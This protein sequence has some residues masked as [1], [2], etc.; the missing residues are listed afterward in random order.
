M[1]IHP[2]DLTAS[3]PWAVIRALMGAQKTEQEKEEAALSFTL[4]KVGL[5]LSGGGFRASLFHIGVLARLAE[6][7]ILRHVEV[8]SCV[9]G[10]SILGAFYYLELR[11][12]LMEK[13]DGELGQQDYIDIV[14]RVQEKFLKGVQKN[15]RLRMLLEF[16]SNLRVFRGSSM[17][18]RL[19]V[20]YD[21]ELFDLVEDEF[22]PERRMFFW[23]RKRRSMSDILITPRGKAGE[24]FDP[25]YDNWTRKHKVPILI[26][27]ATTLNTCHN[28]QFTGNFMGEPPARSSENI[29]SNDRLRRLYY[30]EAPVR[31]RDQPLNGQPRSKV[32]LS[33]AVGASAAVPGLFDPL[34]LDGL[35]GTK[36]GDSQNLD[37]GLGLVDGGAWDNQ[38]AASLL[39]QNC[40][41]LLVSDASGQTGVALQPGSGRLEVMSRTNNILMARVRESQYGYLA[42]LRDAGSLCGLMYVHLKKNLD[43]ENVNWLRSSDVSP[44]S[45]VTVLTTY[46]MRRDVQARIADI[47]TDL[48]SFS[49]CEADALM[50][51]GYLMTDHEFEGCIKGF[52]VDTSLRHKWRFL[53]LAPI[54]ASLKDHA[55]LDPLLRALDIAK[56]ITWKPFFAS[57][58]VKSLTVVIAAGSSYLLIRWCS[59]A[60]AEPLPL[61]RGR[62]LAY[63]IGGVASL[64]VLRLVLNK[65][66]KYRNP[67]IQIVASL[68]LLPVGWLLLPL[69]LRFIEPF[70]TKYGPK[71][72]TPEDKTEGGS[73]AAAAGM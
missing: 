59:S 29:D 17:T 37:Y 11:R 5:A 49:D 10:G 44:R 70:Y 55:D 32:K 60:W 48:D 53:R 68:L 51:S 56:R 63:T 34:S 2:Q 24:H 64:S 71:Y 6:L 72:E 26:L 50:L 38:G 21:R 9:S 40:T 30:G 23:K 16:K 57:P 66:F 12:T 67:Y 43:P 41:V 20:L 47:R 62:A 3:K 22:K 35:Y 54:A 61:T 15:I 13:S 58:V 65:W 33:E 39:D 36:A 27:N 73:K 7:D 28:W 42:T 18:D 8:I 1:N 45:A 52:P 4:G 14:C 69:Y 25:K 19:A 46:G 31:Y